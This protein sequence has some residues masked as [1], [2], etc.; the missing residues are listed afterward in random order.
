MRPFAT[1]GLG[2][3]SVD[4]PEGLGPDEDEL[5]LRVGAG[6]EYTPHQLSNVTFRA[7]YEMDHFNVDSTRSSKD[8]DIQIGSFYAGATYKF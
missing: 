3:I 5:L 4:I 6:L 7:A 8:T 1:L 2:Y